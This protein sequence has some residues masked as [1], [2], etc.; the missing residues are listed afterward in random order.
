V[1]TMGKEGF[2][3]YDASPDAFAGFI[4]DELARWTE[5]AR[6]AGLKA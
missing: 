2:E 3:P 5:V 6:A 1:E 4:D